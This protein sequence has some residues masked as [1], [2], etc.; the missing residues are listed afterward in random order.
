[1]T[2]T[3]FRQGCSLPVFLGTNVLF[4]GLGGDRLGGLG[5]VVDLGV[6]GGGGDRTPCFA[7]CEADHYTKQDQGQ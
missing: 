1:M 5:G 3:F 2:N 6:G 7:G 4:D